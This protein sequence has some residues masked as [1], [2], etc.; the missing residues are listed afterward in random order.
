MAAPAYFSGGRQWRR[1]RCL[2]A[3]LFFASTWWKNKHGDSAAGKQGAD[4]LEMGAVRFDSVSTARFGYLAWYFSSRFLLV[5][6]VI[7]VTGSW[8]RSCEYA[9]EESRTEHVM[10]SLGWSVIIYLFLTE[11]LHW[12]RDW[13]CISSEDINNTVP[14]M[15]KRFEIWTWACFL[16]DLCR[17]LWYMIALSVLHSNC[18]IRCFFSGCR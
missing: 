8:M 15:G 1:R 4:R 13:D 5:W 3:C 11:T 17:S 10:L 16:L 12:L 18:S 7:R 9:P 14:W 2:L 6:S